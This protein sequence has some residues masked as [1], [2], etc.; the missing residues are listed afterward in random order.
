[1]GIIYSPI[2]LITASLEVREARRIRWNRR[3]GEEDDDNVQEW[4]H[5]S[6]EVD[7]EVDDGWRVF[8]E[9]TRADVHLDPCSSEVRQLRTEVAE[10]KDLIK[11]L[12]GESTS[13]S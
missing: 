8:V 2:L 3:R 10:L 11:V 5:V 9:Q 1:M 12:A 13:S 4:E 6:E 7:F